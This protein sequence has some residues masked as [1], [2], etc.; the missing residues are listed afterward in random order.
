MEDRKF[1]RTLA[2]SRGNKK[3]TLK[4]GIQYLRCPAQQQI[5][6]TVGVFG[7]AITMRC[8]VHAE[9]ENFLFITREFL[10]QL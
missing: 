8:P 7:N 1:V 9:G 4:A 2:D 10:L 6:V 3:K 5:K